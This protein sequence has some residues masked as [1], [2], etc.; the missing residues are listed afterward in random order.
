MAQGFSADLC[1]F[2]FVVNYKKWHRQQ[3]GSEAFH[4]FLKS[5]SGGELVTLLQAGDEVRETQANSWESV[6]RLV[7]L[8]GGRGRHI[9]FHY[10]SYSIHLLLETAGKTRQDKPVD[11]EQNKGS[12]LTFAESWV[13]LF[14]NAEQNQSKQSYLPVSRG[15]AV[16]A[17]QRR[18]AQVTGP[19]SGHRLHEER[20][21]GA[22]VDDSHL[23]M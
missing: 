4:C 18:Q 17:G 21:V 3:D 7:F 14:F 6:L 19:A 1:N 11:S 15:V 8:K 20:L 22:E 9:S 2:L 23:V 16:H 10:F 12:V 5:A 13:I